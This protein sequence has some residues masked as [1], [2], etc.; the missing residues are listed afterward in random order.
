MNH[1]RLL[2]TIDNHFFDEEEILINTFD[3]TNIQYFIAIFEMQ[4]TYHKY[5]L[6][7]GKVLTSVDISDIT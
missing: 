7:R 2:M 4:I 6:H 3:F 5:S 1:N